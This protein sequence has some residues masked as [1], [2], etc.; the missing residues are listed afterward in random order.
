MV[1]YAKLVLKKAV[2]LDIETNEQHY[3]NNTLK[4]LKH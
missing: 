1:Y 3:L 4:T 2:D